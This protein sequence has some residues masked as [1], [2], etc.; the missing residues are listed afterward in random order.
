M[1]PWKSSVI[2]SVTHE[3]YGTKA[4]RSQFETKPI[5]PS[6]AGTATI[7]AAGLTKSDG[8]QSCRSGFALGAAGDRTIALKK[9]L[10]LR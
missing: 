1:P 10:K 5:K 4:I 8:I 7:R 9:M 3:V 2:G 6:W